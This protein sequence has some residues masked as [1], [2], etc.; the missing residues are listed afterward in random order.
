M[1][2]HG[3]YIYQHRLDNPVDILLPDAELCEKYIGKIWPDIFRCRRKNRIYS[4]VK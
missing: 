4:S 3:L 1:D 2:M